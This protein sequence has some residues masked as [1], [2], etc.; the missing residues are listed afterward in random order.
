[1][2]FRHLTLWIILF[3]TVPQTFAYF[4]TKPIV[5]NQGYALCTSASCIPDPRHPDYAICICDV[6]KGNSVG[7]SSCAVRAPKQNQYKTK[8]IISTFSFDQFPTKRGMTCPKGMPWTDCVDAPC[9]VNPMDNTKAN[10]S[11]K[12]NHDQAF[13]TLG[14][15]CDIKTCATAFWSGAT[16]AT[17]TLLRQALLEKTK[18]LTKSLITACPVVHKDKK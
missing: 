4:S 18:D 14:G 6:K 17:N 1:M 10:C 15:D 3:F 5:C 7:F 2:R 8:I 12:I 13:F 16:E 9:M 11:C